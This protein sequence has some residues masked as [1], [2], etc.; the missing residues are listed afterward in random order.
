MATGHVIGVGARRR[1]R[2]GAKLDGETGIAIHEVLA[3]E[4][5]E[6]DDAAGGNRRVDRSLNVQARNARDD[7]EREAEII[8]DPAVERRRRLASQI[9]A[10]SWLRGC[11][12][13]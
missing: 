5:C 9:E 11:M 2:A 12:R 8:L 6:Q 13:R 4:I 3:L 7:A 10:V 1:I